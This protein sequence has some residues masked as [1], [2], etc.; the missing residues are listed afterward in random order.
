MDIVN[1]VLL[2]CHWAW[3]LGSLT[4]ALASKSLAL[5]RLSLA[6]GL[7]VL[8][9][10]RW[11]N[12]PLMLTTFSEHLLRFLLRSPSAHSH[13]ITQSVRTEQSNI[14]KSFPGGWDLVQGVQPSNV[15]FKY[16]RPLAMADPGH[17]RPKPSTSLLKTNMKL[18]L[19]LWFLLVV[20]GTVSPSKL[21]S[22]KDVHCLACWTIT[23]HGKLESNGFLRSA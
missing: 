22:V 12:A 7:P 21:P 15:P 19:P 1:T 20:Y 17:G 14:T 6:L 5:W 18:L 10:T 3:N 2:I 16:S 11:R 4:L 23:S 9:N 8:V 13:I